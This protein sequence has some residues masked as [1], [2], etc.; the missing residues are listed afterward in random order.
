MQRLLAFAAFAQA[1]DNRLWL[2]G[3]EPEFV[4]RDARARW[5][6]APYAVE[7]QAVDRV[8]ARLL[9]SMSGKLCHAS[10]PGPMTPAGADKLAYAVGIVFGGPGVAARF[11]TLDALRRAC[12]SAGTAVARRAHTA[13]HVTSEAEVVPRSRVDVHAI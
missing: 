11:A 1:I 6:C 12:T 3:I 8:R 5:A 13:P 9:L 4:L 10:E 2:L 7:L